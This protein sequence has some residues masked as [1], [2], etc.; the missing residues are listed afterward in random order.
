MSDANEVHWV[1]KRFA[2]MVPLNGRVARV[3]RCHPVSLTVNAARA[4]T[5]GHAHALGPALGTLA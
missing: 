1:G 5:V 4:L 2:E 3:C